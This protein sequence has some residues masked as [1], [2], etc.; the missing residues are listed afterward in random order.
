M[1]REELSSLVDTRRYEWTAGRLI[2]ELVA[3]AVDGE[4]VA[5]MGRL[6][7]ELLPE[8]Q[9]V[10]IK[11]SGPSPMFISP[12][13]TQEALSAQQLP[14]VANQVVQDIEFSWL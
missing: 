12:D 10:G 1:S 6:G 3:R 8:L 13:L 7:F 14:A 5:G 2:N 11:G 9:N 4:D